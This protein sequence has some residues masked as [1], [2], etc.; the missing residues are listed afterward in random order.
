MNELQKTESSPA[1]ADTVQELARRI[2]QEAP[3]L[4]DLTPEQLKQIARA[5]VA[6]KL[7]KA[8][9]AKATVAGIDYQ[10]ERE[11]Y[12][13][14]AGKTNSPHTARAYA[15]ALNRLEA[16][17]AYKKLNPLELTRAQADDYAYFLRSEGRSAAT[18][19]RDI[20][21]ASAFFSW[22]ERRH[23][24]LANPFRGSRA[25]PKAKAAK[26]LDIPTAAEVK[27]ILAELKVRDLKLWAAALILA[28]R[29]LRVG[30]LPELTIKGEQFT[31]TT[32]GKEQTGTLPREALDAIKTAGL[33]AR[34]PFA[35][36]TAQ[37]LA[38]HIRWPIKRLYQ[39]GKLAACYSVHDLRHYFAATEY[40]ATKDIYR[41]KQLLGHASISITETYLRS[42]QQIE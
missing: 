10:A 21:A 7:T 27:T 32:K 3:A 9:D 41:I 26:S 13:A 33:D 22:L 31:T 25:R 34:R 35:Q 42:I 24:G 36:D 12:L 40:T 39:A 15:A 37:Q 11:T 20:N 8:L 28:R 14:N 19:R 5:V 18:N 29:G 1:G 2:A 4:A 16:W 30:A 17:T 6:Q 38:D 23:E